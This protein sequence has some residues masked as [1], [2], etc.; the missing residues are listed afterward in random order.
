MMCPFCHIKHDIKHLLFSCLNARVI[1]EHVG[2][3]FNTNITLHSI[4]GV[5]N[6]SAS[7]DW[8]LSFLSYCIYKEWLCH[9]TDLNVWSNINVLN[10]VK[11]I[12]KI[13]RDMYNNLGDDYA[14]VVKCFE[15]ILL[16]SN[17]Q[18]T[19]AIWWIRLSICNLDEMPSM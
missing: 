13:Q 8:F 10:Y 14:N 19:D 18:M 16:W 7:F 9:Y 3:V 4:I 11:S 12:V 17:K 2:T 5:S 6:I 1:W 15:K